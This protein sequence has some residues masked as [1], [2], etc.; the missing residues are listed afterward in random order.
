VPLPSESLPEGGGPRYRRYLIAAGT[1]QYERLDA[2][3]QLPSVALDIDLVSKLFTQR[4]GYE[5]VLR[6]LA[7]SP[8]SGQFRAEISNW[9]IDDDRQPNDLVVIY[10]SGHGAYGPDGRHYLLTRDSAERNLVG[11]AVATEDLVRM[12]GGTVIQH[13]L[14]VI[15][16]C[17]AGAGTYDLVAMLRSVSSSRLVEESAG[18]GLWFVAAARPKQEAHQHAFVPCLVHAIDNPRHGMANQRYL[19]PNS[20]VAAV[21]E[22]LKRSWPHQH[23]RAAMGDSSRHRW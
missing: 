12:L 19:D 10:Y 8:T 17:Y 21:N 23:A 4:L 2:D 18:S 11:T 5:C 16:T 15:D 14:V 9:L 20:V 22:E 3:A 13:A 1:T 6:H 7:D